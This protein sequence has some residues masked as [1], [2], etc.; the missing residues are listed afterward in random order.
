MILCNTL[1][2]FQNTGRADTMT[3]FIVPLADRRTTTCVTE[4]LIFRQEFRQPKSTQTQNK[5]TASLN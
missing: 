4:L 5:A 2:L 1:D 3:L